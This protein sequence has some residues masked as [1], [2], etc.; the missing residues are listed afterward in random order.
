MKLLKDI[1]ETE[2][3]LA[4]N[5]HLPAIEKLKATAKELIAAQDQ[6]GKT[7]VFNIL[8]KHSNPEELTEDL[9]AQMR[10]L[11][12]DSGRSSGWR[13][14]EADKIMDAIEALSKELKT[15]HVMIGENERERGKKD[16][17]LAKIR[18]DINNALE[19]AKE[20]EKKVVEGDKWA[21]RAK[22]MQDTIDKLNGEV[23][24]L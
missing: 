10:A 12:I 11:G 2:S 22:A 21:G 14:G 24:K 5:S 13:L 3:F 20:S 8:G 4:N 15:I 16:D 19:A 9:L 23:E 7:S 1:Q 17:T 18:D 6:E